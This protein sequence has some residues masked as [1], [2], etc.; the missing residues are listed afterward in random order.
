MFETTRS[1]TPAFEQGG[2]VNVTAEMPIEAFTAA[3][4]ELIRRKDDV[5]LD[6][7]TR[8]S[9]KACVVAV[10][11]G[12]DQAADSAAAA[13]EVDQLLSRIDVIA[14]LCSPYQLFAM[15]ATVLDGYRTVYAAN[16]NEY[17]QYPTEFVAG[18]QV[19]LNHVFA[20]GAFL[21]S[22]RRWAE[23]AALARLEPI[24]T[25]DD[26]WKTLLRKME[27]M[28]ARSESLE[29][30]EEGSTR[31][32]VIANAEPAAERLFTLL[33][34]PSTDQVL[35]LLVQFDVYRGIATASEHERDKL[36]AYTNFAFYNSSRAEPAFLTVLQDKLARTAIFG[37]GNDEELRAA[38]R[39]MSEVAQSEGR[40]YSGWSG[41]TKYPLLVFT[42]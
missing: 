35:T 9:V 4:I 39:T 34:A 38:F 2:Y 6:I 14:S 32:G 20:L 40:R 26:Y 28:A 1:N 33:E 42:Q 16:D 29:T 41:F 37:D 31:V 18:H 21:V 27:V 11:A 30:N 12:R 17:M 25:N 7:L 22:E 3:V 8:T 5:G 10:V 24:H 36:G 15:F 19:V 13:A 23:V